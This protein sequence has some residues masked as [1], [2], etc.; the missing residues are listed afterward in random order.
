MDTDKLF[1]SMEELVKYDVDESIFDDIQAQEE[2]MNENKDLYDTYFKIVKILETP[3]EYSEIQSINPSINVN[4]KTI[5]IIGYTQSD[6]KAKSPLSVTTESVIK[7][8]V[9][10]LTSMFGDKFTIKFEE[11]DTMFGKT[12]FIIEMKEK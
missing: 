10:E 11:N 3:I 9:D 1:E 12:Q 8:F 7:L 6:V 2:I 5:V 4:E